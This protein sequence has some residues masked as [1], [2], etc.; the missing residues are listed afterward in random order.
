MTRTR[1]TT[2]FIPKSVNL[3]YPSLILA[4]GNAE[5]VFPT[6]GQRDTITYLF[7]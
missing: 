4:R 7:I 1:Q 6:I 3:F 2:Y 5:S